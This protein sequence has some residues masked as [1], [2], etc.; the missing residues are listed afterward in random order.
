M[1]SFPAPVEVTAPVEVMVRGLSVAG[2]SVIGPGTLVLIV[3]GI[4]LTL[5]DPKISL[6]VQGDEP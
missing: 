6:E 3:L 2:L 1:P 5:F 4:Y